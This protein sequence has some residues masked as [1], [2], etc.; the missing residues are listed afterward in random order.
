MQQS[1]YI[2]SLGQFGNSQNNDTEDCRYD[3]FTEGR[4]VTDDNF[5]AEWSPPCTEIDEKEV[6]DQDEQDMEGQVKPVVECRRLS[7]FLN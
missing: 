1:I 3:D 7:T 4:N 5:P 6:K 2:K